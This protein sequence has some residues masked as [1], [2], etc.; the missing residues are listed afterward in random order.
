M[1]IFV[2]FYILFSCEK[3]EIENRGSS[4]FS[5]FLK[6]NHNCEIFRL[7]IYLIIFPRFELKRK[8]LI[9][10]SPRTFLLIIY[11]DKLEKL[12]Q[13]ENLDRLENLVQ[14]RRSAPS[15]ASHRNWSKC[16]LH[17]HML[18]GGSSPGCRSELSNQRYARNSNLPQIIRANHGSAK[19]KEYPPSTILLAGSSFCQQL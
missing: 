7:F 5:S 8:H 13:L 19:S 11:L 18:C 17:R 2:F 15:G 6:N 3:S 4:H 16:L 10:L 9:F 12:D 14:L 1:L